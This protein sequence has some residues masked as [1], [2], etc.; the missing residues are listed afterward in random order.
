MDSRFALHNLLEFVFPPS[1]LY[2]LANSRLYAFALYGPLNHSNQLCTSS[3]KNKRPLL[4]Y[5]LNQICQRIEREDLISI[6]LHNTRQLASLSLSEEEMIISKAD[7]HLKVYPGKAF[8]PQ[9]NKQDVV[10]LL[11][12]NYYFYECE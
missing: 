6:Y 10:N 3:F 1:S 2:V 12:V 4:D 9:I 11:K 7:K 5:E 8:L